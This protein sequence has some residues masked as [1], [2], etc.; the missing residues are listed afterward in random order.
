MLKHPTT[1]PTS[2]TFHTLSDDTP[3]RHV[4][5]YR[6]SRVGRPGSLA[7]RTF[8]LGNTSCRSRSKSCLPGESLTYTGHPPTALAA[9][10]N[11]PA[12]P[13]EWNMSQSGTTTS[14]M[15]IDMYA[16]LARCTV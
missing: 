11:G 7:R 3:S 15:N 4:S 1:P 8:P 9:A 6:Q 14:P 12:S 5:A 10:C 13:S 16:T 2:L